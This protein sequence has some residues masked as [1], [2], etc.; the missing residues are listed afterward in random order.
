MDTRPARK[1]I[2]I[3]NY[4]YST[5][6][7]YFVTVCVAGKEPIL[8]DNTDIPLTHAAPGTLQVPL[9]PIGQAVEAGILQISTHYA[10]ILVDKYC[11]MPDHIHLILSIQSGSD[12]RILSAPTISTVIG[13]LKR[14]VSRRVGRTIWQKSFIDRVIRS[15][16]GYRAVW[17]YIEN[18]PIKLDSADDRIDLTNI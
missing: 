11:I 13:S 9:S 17:E 16:S 3:E 7:A 5:P 6:G 14:W 18:N 8:W 12:G 4:D 1:K 10:N 2:R 15:D